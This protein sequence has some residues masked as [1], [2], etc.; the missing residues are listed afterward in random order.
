[1]SMFRRYV[2][3]LVRSLVRSDSS[4]SRTKHVPSIYWPDGNI[5]HFEVLN[6]TTSDHRV[7]TTWWNDSA[8]S[9]PFSR[10]ESIFTTLLQESHD[11]N[12]PVL[13][14][15]EGNSCSV[16]PDCDVD[17]KRELR[18]RGAVVGLSDDG[19][20]VRN[21][22]RDLVLIVVRNLPGYGSRIIYLHPGKEFSLSRGDRVHVGLERVIYCPAC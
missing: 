9:W 16:Y 18:D 21:G 8:L 7:S 12:P 15:L 4:E 19:L 22:F 11:Y 1:M 20:F 3:R 17:P 2:G 14:I 13:K 5:A 10:F 6:S